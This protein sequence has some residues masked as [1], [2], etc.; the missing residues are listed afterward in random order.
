[1]RNDVLLPVIP[2]SQTNGNSGNVVDDSLYLSV[3]YN[4][5]N[6]IDIDVTALP[7][8]PVQC[9]SRAQG[10]A[11]IENDASES[12]LRKILDTLENGGNSGST[13]NAPA[14]V[15]NTKVIPLPIVNSVVGNSGNETLEDIL[16][17]ACV[18]ADRDHSDMK[19]ALDGAAISYGFASWA[20]AETQ[21]RK[22]RKGN[23]HD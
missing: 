6:N 21:L 18:I 15:C 9:G 5:N 8:L 19:T 10:L 13:G 12:D 7:V 20:D 2:G 3:I 4:K 11:H 23:Q 14:S 17:D 16:H 22:K 1:M